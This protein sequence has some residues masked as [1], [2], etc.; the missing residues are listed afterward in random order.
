MLSEIADS[1]N[2]KET[3][4]VFLR[5]WNNEELTLLAPSIAD[6]NRIVQW[7]ANAPRLQRRAASQRAER[8][9]K[10]RMRLIGG[11]VTVA[12]GFG[13]LILMQLF[14]SPPSYLILPIGVLVFGGFSL[15]VGLIQFHRA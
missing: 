11:A 10:A 5:L 12:I 8:V 13:L 15:V 7:A 1:S 6:A 14:N 4:E 9:T 3:R 2:P